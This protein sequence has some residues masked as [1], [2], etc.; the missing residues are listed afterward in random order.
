MSASSQR[1]SK[2]ESNEQ[3][4]AR[5]QYSHMLECVQHDWKRLG[6]LLKIKVYCD[7]STVDNLIEITER[8]LN[9]RM[10]RLDKLSI[11]L[12]ADCE[13]SLEKNGKAC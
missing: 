9:E 3:R 1:F 7:E 11:G 8:K 4:L 12:Q 6:K 10:A 13:K 5:V 2:M